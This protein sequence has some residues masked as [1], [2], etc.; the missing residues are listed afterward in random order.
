MSL[1]TALYSG[2]SGL[3]AN[4][5]ELSVVGD[6]IANANTIGFKSARAN[7]ADQMSES[8][9]GLGGSQGERGLGTRLQTIQKLLSQGAI[10]STGIATDLAIQGGGFF[11][12]KG[13]QGGQEGTYFT[14][15]GQFVVNRDGVLTN[16]EGLKVQGYTADDN[17]VVNASALGDLSVGN[18]AALPR[19]TSELTV[20]ANLDA[21]AVPPA[22]FDIANAS[23]T[24]NFSTSMQVFDSLGKA[25]QVDIF[26]RKNGAGDWEW[27]ALSDGGGITGGVPGTPSEI[28]TGTAQFDV[29]GRLTASTSTSTFNPDGATNPQPLT[30]NFGTT[31]PPGSGVDGLTQFAGPSSAAFLNQDGYASGDLS[32][33]SVDSKGEVVGAFSNGQTRILGQVALASFAAPDQL[34]RVGA[35]LYA[36]LPSAGAPNVGQASTSTRGS[37]VAGALEQSNVDLAGEFIR[38]I[39]AQRGFQANSKTL[40]TA[41]ALLAELMT[42]KR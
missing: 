3:E 41:D 20:R 13:S 8:L 2:A 37:I 28:A 4:S 1:L 38:M 27:H 18:A 26:F 29:Q 32:R 39:A 9:I 14:R 42:I 33:I 12:V 10:N 35:N 34:M 19:A 24:S 6:N 7:F 36:S 31:V 5:T 23:T 30:F 11:V 21:D 16:Q 25:H 40:T 17:G 22:P 15:A